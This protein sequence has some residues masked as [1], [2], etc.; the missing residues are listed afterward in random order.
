MKIYIPHLHFTV[1]IIDKKKA[2]EEIREYLKNKNACRKRVSLLHSQIY[3]N[4]PIRK[5]EMSS[6]GHEI[7]HVLQDIASVYDI[8]F[9]KEEEHFGYLFQYIF[10]EATGF[11]FKDKV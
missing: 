3:I 8:D 6:L 11:T 10:N 4:F 7:V 5:N 2:N 9:I 1:E